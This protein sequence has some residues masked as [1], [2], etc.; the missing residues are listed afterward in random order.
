MEGGFGQEDEESASCV[1]R[2]S[3]CAVRVREAVSNISLAYDT[4]VL[5]F[6]QTL[7]YIRQPLRDIASARLLPPIPPQ[8]LGRCSWGIASRIALGHADITF[9]LACLSKVYDT[10]PVVAY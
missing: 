1:Q 8:L 3:D 5:M 9:L 4:I 7:Y 2:L 10:N 6:V